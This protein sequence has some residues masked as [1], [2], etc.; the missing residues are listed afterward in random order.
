MYNFRKRGQR[1]II[2]RDIGLEYALLVASVSH[3]STT[4]SHP[5][6]KNVNDSKS[7]VLAVSMIM[8][9]K[10]LK[11]FFSGK[12][13]FFYLLACGNKISNQNFFS[14]ILTNTTVDFFRKKNNGLWLEFALFGSYWNMQMIINQMHLNSHIFE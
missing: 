2:E 9:F 5:L 12:M 3:V 10:V 13:S 11:S 14:E 7:Y 8:S 6:W 4:L 1:S